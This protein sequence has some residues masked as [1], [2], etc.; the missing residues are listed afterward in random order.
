MIVI[1]QLTVLWN[2]INNRLKKDPG[3]SRD[4]SFVCFLFCLFSVLSVFCFVCFLFCLFSVFV[5]YLFLSVICSLS[6]Y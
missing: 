1:L 4:L 5:C 3:M 6:P 2:F